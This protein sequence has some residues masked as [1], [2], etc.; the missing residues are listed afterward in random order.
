MKILQVS[1]YFEPH[2]GGVE[3]HVRDLSD[4]LV[5]RG[6][7]VTV[8]TSRYEEGLPEEETFM[9]YQVKRV[10]PLLLMFSTPVTPKL[11]RYVLENDFDIVH[12]H[13]PPPLDAYY[14]SKARKKKRFPHIITYHCDLELRMPFGHLG[15]TLYEATYA[16]FTFKHADAAIVTTMG[17]GATSRSVWD[18]KTFTIPNAV[19]AATFNP[20]N[21]GSIVREKFRL[22]N[23]PVVLYVGRLVHHK[24][25]EHLVEA[26]K[27]LSDETRLLVVG[28]GPSKNYFKK[29]A[30]ECRVFDRTTFAGRVPFEL[31]P[32]CFAACDAFV[33]PSVS[34]LEA[35]G[36]VA[37]EAMASEK[38][39][40]V[41]D[42]PGVNEVI[43]PGKQGL[44][45][46][47]MNPRS[48][49]TQVGTILSNPEMASQMGRS[50]RERVLKNFTMKAVAEQVENAYLEVLDDF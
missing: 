19:D 13:W 3:S 24:G 45:C 46:Q 30:I 49:A 28:E 16:S 6:H 34:R 42:I 4:H 31:L 7:E 22:G 2:I 15:V 9:G 43:E 44:L 25:I 35:F 48:I 40:V 50:G 12:T 18:K 10:D 8:V 27:H 1:P 29:R 39:V 5:K 41:S 14:V 20:G 11:K 17:Y 47:P 23:G 26:M 36:I 33:L 38:P 37:L 32:K 21:D